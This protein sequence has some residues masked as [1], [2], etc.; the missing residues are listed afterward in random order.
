MGGLSRA[1][2]WYLDMDFFLV[3]SAR[4]W[5]VNFV[6]ALLGCTWNSSTAV[7]EISL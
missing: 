4:H 1:V 7:G 5:L 2:A 6:Y 3:S